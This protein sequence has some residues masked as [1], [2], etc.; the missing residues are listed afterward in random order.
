MSWLTIQRGDAPLIVSIPH[1]GTDIPSHLETRFVSRWQA[2]VDTDWHVPLVYDFAHEMGATVISTS[3]SRS[4]IDVNRD[5]SGASLY[6]GQATTALCPATTFDGDALYREGKSPEDEEIEDRRGRYF[7]PYHGAIVDEIARLKRAHRSVVLY[8]AH[9]IRSHVPHLFAGELPL[10]NIGTNGGRSCSELLSAAVQAI[11]A[12]SGQPTVANGRFKGGYITR[13]HGQPDRN[14]HAI[15]MELAMRG[16]VREPGSLDDTT[17]PPDY[18]E[19]IAA[20]TKAVLKRVLQA[21]ID[22]ARDS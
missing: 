5:P 6:P 13:S 18:D 4:V 11:A 7:S 22:F 2:R 10:F 9:S 1:A 8:D 14:V 15:Q 21:C 16:Y 17:W 12:G 20:P 3:I 19:A